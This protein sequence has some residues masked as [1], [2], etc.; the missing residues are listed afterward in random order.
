MKNRYTIS[1]EIND[2]SISIFLIGYEKEGESCIF[3]VHTKEPKEVLYSMVIDC[4]EEKNINY[5]MK[6]LEK[7]NKKRKID[8]LIWTHPHDDH[9]IGLDKLIFK[10][11]DKNTQIITASVLNDTPHYTTITNS[12]IHKIA[13]INNGKVP[14]DR[15]KIN[16]LAHFQDILQKIEFT[17]GKDVIEK[18]NIRCIS[19]YPN[20]GNVQAGL[21]TFSVNKMSIGIIVEVIRKKNR[22]NFLFAGDM[23]GQTINSII[24][25]QEDLL[26]D[27]NINEDEMIPSVYNYIK[28]PHHGSDNSSNLVNLLDEENKSELGCTTVFASKNLPRENALRNYS[29]YIKSL[30]CT[31]NININK[32]GTGIILVRYDIK[33]IKTKL[34]HIG[35]A[36][37][38]II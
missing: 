16:S 5:A 20:V 31:S 14:K 36:S 23:E 4:Y 35:T 28:L 30:H 26:A 1:N 6:I 2:I 15:W 17:N 27:M 8:M 38:I 34:K 9:S 11:C 24:E 25:E 32:F 22:L 13:S 21:K 10:M 3:I 19:P 12:L 18:I 37:K 7:Y 33:N 29:N